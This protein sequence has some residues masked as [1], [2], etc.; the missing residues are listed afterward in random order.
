MDNF[1]RRRDAATQR[2]RDK[3]SVLPG[4]AASRRSAVDFFHVR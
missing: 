1:Q 2:S 4:V 3:T